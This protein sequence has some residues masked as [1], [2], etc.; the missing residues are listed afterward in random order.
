MELLLYSLPSQLFKTGKLQFFSTIWLKFIGVLT[1]MDVEN[2]LI[3]SCRFKVEGIPI[4]NHDVIYLQILKILK[5]L[6]IN[7]M[8]N[9]QE[10]F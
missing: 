4:F 5:I 10:I 1:G 8:Q 9:K 3:I 7:D 2:F 6:D